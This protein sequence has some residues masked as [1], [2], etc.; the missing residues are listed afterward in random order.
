MLSS[1][2]NWMINYDEDNDYC[3]DDDDND[4]PD[5]ENFVV[6]KTSNKLIPQNKPKANR[7]T[8]K[9]HKQ[10]DKSA[11]KFCHY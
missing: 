4:E 6:G 7:Q 2:H 9:H 10:M 11:N 8:T 3:E 1:G 5:R